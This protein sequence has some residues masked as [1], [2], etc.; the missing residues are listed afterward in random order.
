MSRFTRIS[1]LTWLA[2]LVALGAVAAVLAIANGSSLPASGASAD[3]PSGPAAGADTAELIAGLRETVRADVT[4]A[5]AAVALGDAYYQRSRETGDGRNYARAERAYAVALAAEPANAAALAGRATIALADHRFADGLALARRAHRVQPQLVAPYAALVDGLIET[6]RYG[7]AAR[8]LERMVG[9]KP[10]LAAYSRISYFRELHGDL[11]GAARALRLAI[12]AGAGTV[13]GAAYVRS[14]LGDLE[15]S[16]GR[17]AAARRAYGEALAVSP[18]YGGAVAGLALLRA[19]RDELGPAIATLRRELGD[20][21]SPD[22]LTELGELE[23]AAGRLG[24]ARRHY[25]QAGRIEAQ[26]LAQGSGYDAGVTL[27][28]AE[29]GDS[30]LA[31]EY[32]RRAWRSA[33][34]VSSADGF[35]WALYRDGRIEAAARMSAE[36]MRLGSGDPSFL[37]HAGMIARAAGESARARRLLSTLLDVA[38]RFNALYAPRAREALRSLR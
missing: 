37:Y 34:S 2:P 26:G 19:G 23:Q 36:A 35:S 21:P 28:E 15:A 10:N 13:E 32:G 18:G 14:L 3:T 4:N 31:V 9:A 17:Y 11:E 38:P 20:P 8:A 22:A 24:A 7:E 33:P 1:N 29:H 27:N 5:E 30:A 16:R 12:S 25:A 6:G